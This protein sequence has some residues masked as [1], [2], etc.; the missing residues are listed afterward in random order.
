MT[1]LCVRPCPV[2]HVLCHHHFSPPPLC[3]CFAGCRF[4][5]FESGFGNF[6]FPKV[7]I[8]DCCFFFEDFVAVDCFCG[9]ISSGRNTGSQTIFHGL[10][11]GR[12]TKHIALTSREL[13]QSSD[14][15]HATKRNRFFDDP[16]VRA[17]VFL[18]LLLTCFLV[19]SGRAPSCM[20][21]CKKKS[22]V[23]A[24]WKGPHSLLCRPPPVFH[25]PERGLLHVCVG[26]E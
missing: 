8:S 9:G 26:V 19:I 2:G 18:D 6:C 11:S 20:L 4:D 13:N 12:N 23:V 16:R 1:L 10:G 5:I 24:F 17:S 21:T 7:M 3:Y 22:S 25:D 14:A 15:L